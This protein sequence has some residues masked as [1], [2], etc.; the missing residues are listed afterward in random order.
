MTIIITSKK[1]LSSA[2]KAFMATAIV[3]A[4][5]VVM[6][7]DEGIYNVVKSIYTERGQQTFEYVEKLVKSALEQQ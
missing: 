4:D 1:D 2:D 5:I 3:D 7:E 6:K